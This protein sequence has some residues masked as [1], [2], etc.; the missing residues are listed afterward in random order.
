[1][2][3]PSS[4]LVKEDG[5]KILSGLRS[6][7]TVIIKVRR[8]IDGNIMGPPPENAKTPSKFC[9]ELNRNFRDSEAAPIIVEGSTRLQEGSEESM[10]SVGER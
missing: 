8:S 2:P 6:R 3:C 9:E 4:T 1:M 10:S 5:R 7:I